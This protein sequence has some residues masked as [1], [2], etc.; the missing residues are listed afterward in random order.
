M[1][2]AFI[3]Y[4]YPPDSA[5]G[6]IATYVEQAVRLMHSRGHDVEV[7]AASLEHEGLVERD[8][9]IVHRICERDREAFARRIAPV[10]RERHAALPFDVIEGPEYYADAREITPLVPDIPL[11]VKLHTPS[12]LMWRISLGQSWTRNVRHFCGSLW[13]RTKPCWDPQCNFE[14]LHAV[15]ADEVATPCASLGELCV[16]GWKLDPKRTSLVP[17]PFVP[18]PALLAVP[19]ESRQKVVTF[20]G[21]LEV[22]KGVLD[23]AK[24]I[25]AILRRHPDAKFKFVGRSVEIKPGV[26]MR[27]MLK[28]LLRNH[29]DAIEFVGP[30]NRDQLPSILQ[31]SDVCVF[32]SIWENFPNVCLEAMAA[33]RAIVASSEGGMEEMLNHGACGRLVK[34]RRPQVLANAVIE[35]LNDSA[36]REKMGLAARERILSEYNAARIGKLQEESYQ[37]AIARRRAVGARL[38]A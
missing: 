25:P 4:E 14:W 32:P 21:R 20:I 10:F 33:G 24:A 36:L 8:G 35:L 15:D 23:L 12:F 2:L 38:V 27:E 18:P 34:P 37:R 7:F 22:R 30:V 6:G 26:E 13:R 1:R 28:R 5:F 3:S 29:M 11:V 16:R 17:Y 19:V 9:V 31:A